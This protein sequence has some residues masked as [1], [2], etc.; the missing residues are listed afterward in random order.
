MKLEQSWSAINGPQARF[1]FTFSLWWD[2]CEDS[3]LISLF[4]SPL[5]VAFDADSF[6]IDLASLSP[7]RSFPCKSRRQRPCKRYQCFTL[8]LSDAGLFEVYD[9]WD[10]WTRVLSDIMLA[11]VGHRVSTA[12]PK[13]SHFCS[14]VGLCKSA[15]QINRPPQ[16]IYSRGK[17]ISI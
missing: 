2:S 13:S 10:R 5:S 11:R 9:L 14:S 7:T 12:Q 8:H 17:Q 6:D 15:M 1:K 4:P 3:P 16:P